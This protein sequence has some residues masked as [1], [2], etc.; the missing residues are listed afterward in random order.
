MEQGYQLRHS[1][2]IVLCLI[3]KCCF[4]YLCNC[5]IPLVRISIWHRAQFLCHELYCLRTLEE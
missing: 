3:L 5:I 4:P 2:W 1:L